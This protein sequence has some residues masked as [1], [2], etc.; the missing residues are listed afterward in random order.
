MGDRVTRYLATGNR[1]IDKL[2]ELQRCPYGVIVAE[3]TGVDYQLRKVG[4]TNKLIRCHID[5]L[6]EFK[7]FTPVTDD[8]VAPEAAAAPDSKVYA[9]L[10]IMGEKKHSARL[11][12]ARS[13][14]IQWKDDTDGMVHK[15]TW[16]V[17]ENLTHCDQ[18]MREW[19]K[20]SISEKSDRLKEAQNTVG[21]A[22]IGGGINVATLTR[23]RL[24]NTEWL[25]LTDHSQTDYNYRTMLREICN[26]VGLKPEQVL[27]LWGSPPCETISPA[28]AMNQERGLAYRMYSIPH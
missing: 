21:I 2:S 17:E 25:V 13:F 4:T 6:R 10:R 26:S 8:S 5:H 23:H 15:C 24:S 20:L 11:G 9:A 3:P 22:A 12:G 18:L 14:L 28:G 16:E 27:L 1:T 19:L 7:S